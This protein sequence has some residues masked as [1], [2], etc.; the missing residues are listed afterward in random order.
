MGRNTGRSPK[1]AL[2]RRNERGFE[3]FEHKP[4]RNQLAGAGRGSG[5]LLAPCSCNPPHQH[6]RHSHSPRPGRDHK[7]PRISGHSSTIRCLPESRRRASAA[8]N[9]LG[10]S[11]AMVFDR[12]CILACNKGSFLEEVIHHAYLDNSHLQ[13][14]CAGLYFG[15][16]RIIVKL[17]SWCQKSN[18]RFMG[19]VRR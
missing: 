13:T 16:C 9:V 3:R 19:F 10:A 7:L 14:C 6:G 2:Q 18:G 11:S 8:V 1:V 4:R 17:V 5:A 12:A 15:L